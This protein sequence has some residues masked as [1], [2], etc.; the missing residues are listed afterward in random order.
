MKNGVIG[1]MVGGLLF[2]MMMQMMGM[3]TMVAMLV[4]SESV[5]VGWFIHLVI[6]AF[7]G[8][9][10]GWF[11]GDRILSAGSGVKFGAIYGVIWW[12]LGALILMPL[13]LGMNEM[14]G[15]IGQPQMMSL[16]GHL[17]WGMV[18]GVVFYQLTKK[19]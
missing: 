14:I 1:G 17:I 10:F 3:M 5:V 2:G 13:I 4:G 6:S 7:T 15:K 12:I 16:L 11:Y 19:A 18:M 8:A 9:I